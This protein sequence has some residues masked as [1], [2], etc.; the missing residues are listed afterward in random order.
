MALFEGPCPVCGG[1]DRFAVSIKKQVFNCRGCG[2]KAR[3]H[4]RSFNFLDGPNF[5]EAV[6]SRATSCATATLLTSPRRRRRHQNLQSTMTIG[7][8]PATYGAPPSIARGTLVHVYLEYRKLDLPDEIAV[9]VKIRFHPN[10]HSNRSI[11]GHDLPGSGHLHH[12][13]K[14][15]TA[16]PE[17]RWSRDQAQREN[18]G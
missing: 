5:K 3:R 11:P 15:S 14:Q 17:P 4:L 8:A 18:F 2:A 7:S 16:R 1:T 6:E 12:E 13:R 9:A 10:C